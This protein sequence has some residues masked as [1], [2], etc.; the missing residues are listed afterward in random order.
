MNTYL[1]LGDYGKSSYGTF[2]ILV[3]EMDRF[4][5]ESPLG[6]GRKTYDGKLVLSPR[7][8]IQ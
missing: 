3:N 7:Y 8:G 5:H 4:E 2:E 1:Y 6:I